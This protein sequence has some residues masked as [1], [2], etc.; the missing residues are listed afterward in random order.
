RR[1]AVRL[2]T[3]A[4]DVAGNAAPRRSRLVITVDRPLAGRMP[5]LDVPSRSD[6]TIL[7]HLLG[8]AIADVP[9]AVLR[10]HASTEDVV[11]TGMFSVE[12]ARSRVGRLVARAMRMPSV[13]GD[14][15]VALSI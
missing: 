7:G 6:P 1:R 14:T 5:E 10:F 11:G 2:G 8:P 3:S 12:Q 4:V 15:P 13:D 9:P